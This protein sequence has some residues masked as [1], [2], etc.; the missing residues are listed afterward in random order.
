MPRPGGGLIVELRLPL[1]G[2]RREV[3]QTTRMSMKD[4]EANRGEA[5]EAPGQGAKNPPAA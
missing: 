4:L 2:S 3:Q 5:G 1:M